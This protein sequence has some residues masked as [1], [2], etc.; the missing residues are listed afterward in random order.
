MNGPDRKKDLLVSD[1]ILIPIDVP[2]SLIDRRGK[3]SVKK[4][5]DTSGSDGTDDVEYSADAEQDI[6][7]DLDH[8][9]INDALL[10]MTDKRVLDA[11][12]GTAGDII[13]EDALDR[14]YA[15]LMALGK[16]SIAR[17]TPG[18][19][20]LFRIPEISPF[21]VLLPQDEQ[22]LMLSVEPRTKVILLSKRL[23]PEHAVRLIVSYIAIEYESAIEKEGYVMQFHGLVNHLK[24]MLFPVLSTGG[25]PYE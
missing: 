5:I 7:S 13:D 19:R 4:P 3:Q 23:T 8:I 15:R 24:W 9:N 16:V 6:G 2:A 21:Y 1:A 17:V 14:I 22:F 20:T 12:I 25:T 10:S 18:A 11:Y